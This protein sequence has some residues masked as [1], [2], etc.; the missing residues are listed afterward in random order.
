M[1]DIHMTTDELEAMLER[2]AQ[3]AAQAA[4]KEIGLHGESAVDDM[5][6]IRSLLRSFRDARTVISS[7]VWRMVTTGIVLFICGAVWL[8]FKGEV[9]K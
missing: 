6:E 4:L 3:K 9:N 5:R 1:G 7:T 2:V 8:A